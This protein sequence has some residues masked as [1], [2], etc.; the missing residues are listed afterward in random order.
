MKKSVILIALVLVIG[1][2]LWAHNRG[3]QL[4][5]TDNMAVD[6]IEEIQPGY[7]PWVNLP[8]QPSGERSEA[9]RLALQATAGSGL[10][11]LYLGYVIRRKKGGV[12]P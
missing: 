8:W 1:V 5:G 2:A 10:V 4:Q 12:K 7:S 3:S 9:I 6:A 11:C